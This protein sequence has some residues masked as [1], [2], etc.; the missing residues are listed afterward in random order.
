M[1]GAPISQ[2]NSIYW[3]FS[4]LCLSLFVYGC[5]GGQSQQH[6]TTPTTTTPPVSIT[7]TVSPTSAAINTGQ[8]TQ[9]TAVVTG[10][11]SGVTWAVNGVAGGNSTLGTIDQTGKFAAPSATPS[12][13]VMIT[14]TSTVDTSKSASA[15]VEIV[16][17]ATV[18]ATANP[19]VALLTINS[20]DNSNVSVQFG[21]TTN[22]GLT[23]S[24]QPA[25]PATGPVSLFVAGMLANTL[26]H[27][28]TVIQFGDGTQFMDADQVFTTGAHPPNQL[29]AL[30][31]TTTP[32]MTPQSGVELL[33]LVVTTPGSTALGV[34]VSDLSGNV[35]WS[36]NAGLS[37]VGAD[38]SS[39]FRM[40]ISSSISTTRPATGSI[41]SCRRWTSPESS[42]GK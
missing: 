16:A 13:K 29:P 31:A 35:L 37:G 32:G 33:D 27:M 30:T 17:P 19:Q 41:P 3:C 12:S 10:D 38:P 18:A 8:S 39:C 22:Y 6:P 23:T 42:S 36:Y 40:A 1:I 34:A 21:P 28:R 9:F 14:A 4:F 15:S 24:T 7:V 25:A 26:Y 11:N 5:G 20:P 2:R